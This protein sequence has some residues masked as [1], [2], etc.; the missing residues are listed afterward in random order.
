MFSLCG[1]CLTGVPKKQKREIYYFDLKSFFEDEILRL[2]KENTVINKVVRHNKQSEQK[3]IKINNWATELSVFVSSDINK[4]AFEKS[5]TKDSSATKIVYAAKN[6]DLETQRITIYLQ[7]QKPIFI[8]IINQQNNYLFK[9][10]ENLK[11]YPK[12]A[13]A[14]EKK[15]K[16]LFWETEVYEVKG[17]L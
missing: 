5:Y 14:I 15:Q 3:R 13:Y 6:E 8:N 16:L 17:E 9:S 7:N 1:G 11:Y 2:T 10:W 12:K 4:A